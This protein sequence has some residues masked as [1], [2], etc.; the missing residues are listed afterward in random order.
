MEE[1]EVNEGQVD[2]V[3]TAPNTPD[4]DA[5]RAEIE[6]RFEEKE[7]QFQKQYQGL[8]KVVAKK[9]KEIQELKGKST[10][11]PYKRII[12]EMEQSEY[13]DPSR[14]Q[15][16]RAELEAAENEERMNQALAY[17][18]GEKEKLTKQIEEAGFDPE[19]DMFVD[20]DIAYDNAFY[21][22]GDFSKAQK[23]LNQILK[24]N[25]KE[26]PKVEEK[27]LTIDDIPE[28]LREEIY[29]Q[30]MEKSGQLDTE[31]GGPSAAPSNAMKIMEAYAKGEAT[32]A[33]Y[34]QA[35]QELGINP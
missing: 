20:V 23:K 33:Q 25:K 2:E 8:Q 10:T 35:C 22:N 24:Q 7:K 4:L 3:Q 13:A 30:R 16:L 6:S 11:S 14:L 19:D 15:R 5:F 29:R 28:E 12:E 9:D 31:E 17:A 34:K 21:G 32:D 27:K 26:V 18:Q 1:K